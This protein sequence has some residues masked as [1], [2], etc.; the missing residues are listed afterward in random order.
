MKNAVTVMCVMLLTAAIY[1]S[2]ALVHNEASP[3]AQMQSFV[4]TTPDASGNESE[5]PTF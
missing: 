3:A 4:G 1:S 2:A 5:A